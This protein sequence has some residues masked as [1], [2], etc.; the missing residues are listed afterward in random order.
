[1]ASD[2][3][4]YSTVA[5]Q[6][7]VGK[8]MANPKEVSRLF[9]GWKKR[10]SKTSTRH[11]KTTNQIKVES[12][13]IP[14]LIFSNVTRNGILSLTFNQKIMVPSFIQSATRSTRQLLAI[15]TIDVS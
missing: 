10:L 2:L 6:P 5:A 11:S 9:D 13:K 12:K 15:D 3:A 8:T 4:T 7:L 14:L 1:M